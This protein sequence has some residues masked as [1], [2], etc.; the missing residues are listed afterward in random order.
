[1]VTSKWEGGFVGPGL[2]LVVVVVPEGL[3]IFM[4]FFLP[5]DFPLGGTVIQAFSGGEGAT[6]W[7]GGGGVQS[8]SFVVSF[9]VFLGGVGWVDGVESLS[10]RTSTQSA[11]QF[12]SAI[13]LFAGSELAAGGG[14]PCL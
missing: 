9:V 3:V 13:T 2:V 12:R 1:M 11:I 14:G 6:G 4:F 8:R 7:E 10:S 5:K